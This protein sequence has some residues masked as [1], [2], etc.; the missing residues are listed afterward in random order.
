MQLDSIV[1]VTPLSCM[2]DRIVGRMKRRLKYTVGDSQTPDP[3]V[4]S[5]DRTVVLRRGRRS[6][7][8]CWHT[9]ES[10]WMVAGSG[11]VGQFASEGQLL[12]I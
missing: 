2:I 6:A 7:K 12:A 5:W 9:F 1:A 11:K 10:D 4:F 3:S 8:T